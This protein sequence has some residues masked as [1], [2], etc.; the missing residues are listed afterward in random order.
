MIDLQDSV[1][2]GNTSYLVYGPSLKLLSKITIPI[3]WSEFFKK[4]CTQEKRAIFTLMVFQTMLTSVLVKAFF[5]QHM[6]AVP[7]DLDGP[8]PLSC[9]FLQQLKKN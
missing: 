5:V 9:G 6:L 1:S 2:G 4:Y 7:Y 8:P 3:S